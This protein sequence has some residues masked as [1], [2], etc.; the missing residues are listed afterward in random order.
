VTWLTEDNTGNRKGKFL[1]IIILI[2]GV[3][4]FSMI[5]VLKLNNNINGLEESNIPP[6]TPIEVIVPVEKSVTPSPAPITNSQA[7]SSSSTQSDSPSTVQPTPAPTVQ[8]TS[9]PIG[10]YH[11]ELTAYLLKA[12]NDERIAQGVTPVVLGAAPSAQIHADEMLSQ[13][14]FSFW[15]LDGYPFEVRYSFNGSGCLRNEV[16]AF[17]ELLG[18]QDFIVEAHEAIDTQVYNMMHEEGV[19]YQGFAEAV[20]DPLSVSLSLGLAYNRS[21]IYFVMDFESHDVVWSLL[22]ASVVSQVK[23]EGNFTKSGFTVDFLEIFYYKPVSL[24]V[25]QLNDKLYTDG[26]YDSVIYAAIVLPPVNPGYYWDW[27]V[28]DTDGIEAYTWSQNEFSFRIA[29]N[30]SSIV[31]KYGAGVYMVYLCCED[32]PAIIFNTFLIV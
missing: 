1:V 24:T 9:A 12:I 32:N 21:A 15:N 28:F 17:N 2:V 13:N 29:F 5:I 11:D 10:Q 27:S 14:Y 4:F 26:L 20:L 6:P 7:K 31:N 8:P 19:K 30:M 16:M 22:N 18:M 23:L 3:L 25:E